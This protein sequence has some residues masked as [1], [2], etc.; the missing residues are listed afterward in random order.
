LDTSDVGYDSQGYFESMVR[1]QV[2]ESSA[3][4]TKSVYHRPTDMSDKSMTKFSLGK[5][6]LDPQRLVP[7]QM[8][9]LRN[10]PSAITTLR[11]DEI[12]IE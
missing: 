5:S 4:Q 6:R 1:K 7:S 12:L 8:T 9:T 3:Q 2:D 11:Y 10:H